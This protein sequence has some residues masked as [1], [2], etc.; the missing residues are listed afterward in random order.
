MI[1]PEHSRVYCRIV[2]WPNVNTVVSQTAERP[3]ER[4][5]HGGLDGQWSNQN[6]HLRTP[7]VVQ[8]LR[9]CLSMQ[10]T[11]VWS[12]VLEDSTYRQ[13]TEPIHSNC[14][15]PCVLEPMLHSKRSHCNEKPTYSNKDPVQLKLNH[16]KKKKT[17]LL[18]AFLNGHG[19]QCPKQLQFLNRGTLLAYHHNK[20]ESNF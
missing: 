18:I 3:E 11:R 15:S 4:E 19:S 10:V 9:I 8:W 1:L 20:Y 5:R 14:W 17:H 6:T 12:L 16:L 13:A 7:L 2:N